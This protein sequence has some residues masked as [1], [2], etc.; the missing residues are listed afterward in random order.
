[1]HL[2]SPQQERLPLNVYV[3]TRSGYNRIAHDFFGGL[4]QAAERG[5]LADPIFQPRTFEEVFPSWQKIYDRIDIKDDAIGQIN[6]HQPR[7]GNSP[8]SEDILKSLYRSA[9]DKLEF[10]H[11]RACNTT[12]NCKFGWDARVRVKILQTASGVN[13]LT[14][15]LCRSPLSL[16]TSLSAVDQPAS[17]RAATGPDTRRI[18]KS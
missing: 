12:F 5:F 18:T 2:T 16:E 11:T 17:W 8:G 6:C 1:V 3:P 15:L 10:I 13:E 4:L 7:G 14:S 9:P